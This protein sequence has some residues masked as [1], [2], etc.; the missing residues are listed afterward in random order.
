MSYFQQQRKKGVYK[1]PL[2]LTT[3]QT[4]AQLFWEHF[5]LDA[6]LPERWKQQVTKS[7]TWNPQKRTV[8]QTGTVRSR[9]YYMVEIA[10]QLLQKPPSWLQQKDDKVLA[11][12]AERIALLKN[13][14]THVSHNSY[15]LGYHITVAQLLTPER[16]YTW[17]EHIGTQLLKQALEKTDAYWLEF[18]VR[19]FIFPLAEPPSS[20]SFR[21][22]ISS[23]KENHKKKNSIQVWFVK[24]QQPV[25]AYFIEWTQQGQKQRKQMVSLSQPT[26]TTEKL[27]AHLIS[28]WESFKELLPQKPSRQKQSR[29]RAL[30]EAA[31]TTLQ[32]TTPFTKELAQTVYAAC[33]FYQLL[34]NTQEDTKVEKQT[35]SSDAVA[36]SLLEPVL[37]YINISPEAQKHGSGFGG[38]KTFWSTYQETYDQLKAYQHFYETFYQ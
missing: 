6:A 23:D 22:S 7:L 19:L 13:Y 10:E 17:R 28:S 8:A 30:Q 25:T 4:Q 1:L 3:S 16:W 9:L 32:V 21:R 37:D 26:T 34:H 11:R 29:F 27:Q 14:A 35:T 38:S 33:E 2:Y 24:Q 18:V 31:H 36:W 15:F 12:F 5:W 20:W